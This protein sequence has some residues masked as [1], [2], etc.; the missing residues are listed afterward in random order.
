MNTRTLLLIVALPVAMIFAASSFAGE[1]EDKIYPSDDPVVP[2]AKSDAKKEKEEK[3]Q[4]STVPA[5]VQKPLQ[6]TRG[7]EKLRK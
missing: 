5:V 2:H 6:K 7:A 3:V 4:W 1:K